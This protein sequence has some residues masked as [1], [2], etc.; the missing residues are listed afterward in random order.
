[1]PKAVKGDATFDA[2]VS[3]GLEVPAHSSGVGSSIASDKHYDQVAFFPGTTHN[4]FTGN[5]GVFDYDAVILQRSVGH[6]RA[7]GLQRLSAVLHER[8]PTA[9]V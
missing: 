8:P 7:E 5:I 2:L 1:M 4:C 3:K 9:V 6:A